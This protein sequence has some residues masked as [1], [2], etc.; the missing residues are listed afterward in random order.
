MRD[1]QPFLFGV[2]LLLGST[3]GCGRQTPPAESEP[4]E[5]VGASRIA[6]SNT[7]THANAGSTADAPPPETIPTPE[8]RRACLGAP[9]SPG[10]EQLPEVAGLRHVAA[11]EEH[12][13]LPERAGQDRLRR[14]GADAVA[15]R[16][17]AKLGAQQSYGLGSC[18]S[19]VSHRAFA[20]IRLT[21]PICQPWLEE[22]R[23]VAPVARGEGLGIMVEIQGRTGPRCAAGEPNCG[24]LPY[25]APIP[26]AHQESRNWAGDFT[27]PL[28][29]GA[30]FQTVRDDLGSGS[31]THAGDCVRAG[32]GNHCDVWYQPVYGAN[33]P[34]FNE[35][36]DAYCGC[37]QG[38]CAWF[39]QPEIVQLSAQVDVDNW[40]GGIPRQEAPQPQTAAELFARRLSDQWM[41]RQMRRLAPSGPLP[42]QLE[43]SFTWHPNTHVTALTMKADGQPAPAWLVTLFEHL[44]MPQP[45]ARPFRPVRVTGTLQISSSDLT[46]A[47]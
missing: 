39:T 32:C 15:E 40:Q 45:E 16:V 43:F 14:D 17:R 42:N 4:A 28:R 12:V 29:P 27:L 26:G 37:V 46:A 31:C 2:T 1:F 8:E 6:P 11:D 41:S 3:T 44:R 19:D 38:K 21:V 7:A 35:L 22:V 18:G 24:P 23:R 20:C 47:E 36:S 34:A 5:M 33:C 9:L 30:A 10:P 13:F 25:H